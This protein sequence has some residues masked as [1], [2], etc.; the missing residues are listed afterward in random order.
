S[1]GGSIWLR[2]P[3]T[4]ASIA[5]PPRSGRAQ[6]GVVA[7]RRSGAGRSTYT[8]PFMPMPRTRAWVMAHGTTYIL[9]R[10]PLRSRARVPHISL[11]GAA[12]A[13]WHGIWHGRGQRRYGEGGGD[14]VAA[15]MKD[16]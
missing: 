12:L 16:V 10:G 13:E 2:L 4:A 8:G 6:A 11:L 7:R 5:V 15:T 1:A 3:F 9:G 14:R